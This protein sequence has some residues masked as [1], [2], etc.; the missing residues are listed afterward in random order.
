MNRSRRGIASN[1]L[2][3]RRNLAP[4][5]VFCDYEELLDPRHMTAPFDI[6]GETLFPIFDKWATLSDGSVDA[7]LVKEDMIK[8]IQDAYFQKRFQNTKGFEINLS[9]YLE[10]SDAF[11]QL[12]ERNTLILDADYEQDIAPLLYHYDSPFE[13]TLSSSCGKRGLECDDT[14]VQDFSNPEAF[15]EDIKLIGVRASSSDP[16]QGIERTTQTQLYWSSTGSDAPAEPEYLL[17]R[18]AFPRPAL[19]KASSIPIFVPSPS[20]DSIDNSNSI[21]NNNRNV[22]NNDNNSHPN[23]LHNPNVARDAGINNEGFRRDDFFSLLSHLPPHPTSSFRDASS[24][25]AMVPVI[26][27]YRGESLVWPVSEEMFRQLQASARSE[28]EGLGVGDVSLSQLNNG[29]GAGLGSRGH[30]HLGMT[31]GGVARD[32]GSAWEGFRGGGGGGGDPHSSRGDNGIGGNNGVARNGD[33]PHLADDDDNSNNDDD[34]DLRDNDEADVI[35]TVGPSVGGIAAVFP[36]RA[37]RHFSASSI[38]LP[39]APS[40]ASSRPPRPPAGSGSGSS[41]MPLASRSRSN[42]E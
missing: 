20:S 41:R 17:Y 12:L 29:R 10:S 14:A 8:S 26:V 24:A 31:N 37:P 32:S 38:P 13:E 27:S 36:S 28:S 30:G 11:E 40:S 19:S 35:I 25:P 9:T 21:T 16:N 5:S 33:I 15:L 1:L 3:Q 7:S 23:S 39:T 6:I 18:F 2:I 22:S 42:F 34:D 4:W